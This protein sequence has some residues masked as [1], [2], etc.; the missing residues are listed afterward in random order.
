M[1]ACERLTAREQ[2]VNYPNAIIQRNVG[3]IV[4]SFGSA[5]NKP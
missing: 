5:R 4:I 1:L 2:G 3:P